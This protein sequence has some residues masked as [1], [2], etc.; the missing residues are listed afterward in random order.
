MRGRM[1]RLAYLTLTVVLSGAPTGAVAQ[2]AEQPHIRDALALAVERFDPTHESGLHSS[3]WR[4]HYM[5]AALEAVREAYPEFRG[6]R[7]SEGNDRWLH[8]IYFY[9]FFYPPQDTAG[10]SVDSLLSAT[11]RSLISGCPSVTEQSP[12]P[13]SVRLPSDESQAYVWD[14]SDPSCDGPLRC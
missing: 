8:R 1:S 5:M 10:I 7:R 14:L 4:V 6:H 11:A 3:D 2:E 9:H 12:S 13:G